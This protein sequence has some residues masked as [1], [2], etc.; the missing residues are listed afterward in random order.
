MGGMKKKNIIFVVAIILI[1]LVLKGYDMYKD[2]KNIKEQNKELASK[3]KELADDPYKLF[4]ND[5][6]AE[7]DYM[8]DA[9]IGIG[10]SVQYR[11]DKNEECTKFGEMELKVNSAELLDAPKTA[12]L[13]CEELID[14]I[15]GSTRKEL[16]Y[17]FEEELRYLYVNFTIK[18]IGHDT[19]EIEMGIFHLTDS[20]QFGKA[21][22]SSISFD[23]VKVIENG[24]ATV[25]EEIPFVGKKMKFEAGKEY[26]I[27]CIQIMCPGE[28]YD[29]YMTTNYNDKNYPNDQVA[30]KLDI[31][32]YETIECDPTDGVV[33]E[34]QKRDLK[35]LRINAGYTNYSYFEDQVEEYEF[36]DNHFYEFGATVGKP[37]EQDAGEV[38]PGTEMTVL[39][40]EL[41]NDRD[42]LPERFK[43]S[44]YIDGVLDTY[45]EQLSYDRD[46]YRYVYVKAKFKE[47][48]NLG[49][50]T[51][52]SNCLWLYN[53]D[54]ENNLWVFGCADDYYIESSTNKKQ[55]I[56]YQQ[57]LMEQG[58]EIVVEAVYVV[59]PDTVYD[60]Y[61]Y[62]YNNGL[63]FSGDTS[64]SDT[65]GAISL[66]IKNKESG[67]IK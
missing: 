35:Q 23:V 43:D 2:N 39:E 62:N 45:M 37:L 20:N 8:P 59:V 13:E 41:V 48:G 17:R 47:L 28:V 60:L 11:Y 32:L 1:C 15:K 36:S 54:D 30:V 46:E 24:N 52:L 33:S 38:I 40:A 42:N 63:I 14:E 57:I 5:P 65:Y 29:L 12:D 9:M 55:T 26:N 50:P 27:E 49:I 10:D 61:I 64:D 34:F 25:I 66:D 4:G 51:M 18:N 31:A 58:E 7:T 3:D 56:E 6:C 53:R 44:K 19:R 22:G 67:G 16:L 21:D